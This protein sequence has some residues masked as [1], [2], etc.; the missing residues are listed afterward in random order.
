MWPSGSYQPKNGEYSQ[1]TP[2]AKNP[3]SSGRNGLRLW[4]PDS[5]GTPGP[6]SSSPATPFI[7][8]N[9]P[10]PEL[11]L[12]FYMRYQE[13]FRWWE[14]NPPGY[15]K[16]FRLWTHTHGGDP[17]V[18]AHLG[19]GNRL[20]VALEYSITPS[21]YAS[22]KG[23]YPTF[24]DNGSTSHGRWV[25]YEMHIKMESA[26]YA[27]DGELRVWLNGELLI[28]NTSMIY[29]NP[30]ANTQGTPEAQLAGWVHTHVSNQDFVQNAVGP[31]GRNVAYVDFDDIVIYN[32]TPPNVDAHGN[33]FI[34]PIGWDGTPILLPPKL[35][36]VVE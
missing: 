13:G 23:W 34:G 27:A 29:V 31:I 35:L 7:S 15:D 21:Q 1:T 10:Q 16:L 25:A 19:S 24:S 32:Q 18:M 30:D 3:L 33:P 2:E 12:R 5:T 4:Y 26:P 22:G 28:E 17:N 11:W 9:G 36:P 14:G 6:A 20:G 8:F